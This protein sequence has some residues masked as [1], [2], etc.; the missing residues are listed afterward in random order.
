[1]L[2]DD[3]SDYCRFSGTFNPGDKYVILLTFHIQ[4][5]FDGL[6][7]PFLADNFIQRLYFRCVLEGEYLGITNTPEI[8]RAQFTFFSHNILL[9]KR[10]VEK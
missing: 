5:K 3:V 8:G 1:M 4:A 7:S 6:H 9:L 10:K 2:I